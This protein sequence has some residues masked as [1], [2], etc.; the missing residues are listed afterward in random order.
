MM[1]QHRVLTPAVMLVRDEAAQGVLTQAV[2][3]VHDE[4]AQGTDAGRDTGA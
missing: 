4:T 1:K 2:M 3:L